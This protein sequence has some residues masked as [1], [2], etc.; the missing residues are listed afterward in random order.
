[1]AMVVAAVGTA[2]AWVGQAAWALGTYATYAVAGA[3]GLSLGVSGAIVSGAAQLALSAAATALMTPSIGRG[4]SPISFKAD[5]SAPISGVMGRFG[6]GGR[7]LHANVWGKDN[8]YLSFAVALSLGPIQSVEGFTA[9]GEA[10]TFPGAQGLAADVEPYRNKMW[11][12]YRLGLPTDAYLSPPTGVSDG[13]PA[14]TEWTSAHTLPG[15]AQTFWTMKNNSKREGYQSGV[16][17][18]LWTLLGMKVWDPRLDSTYPGGS[19]SQRRTDWTTWAYSANPYLHALA[20]VRGHHKL[21]AGGTI[22]T[23]KRLAGVGAPDAAIDIAAF[24]EGANVADANSWEIS[25][26]WTTADDKWQTLAAMLQAGGGVPISQGAQI[27]CMVEA[28]RTSLMTVTGED[29]VGSVSLNVM[30]SRRDRPNTVIPRV[31]LEAHKFEEVALGAVTSSTYVTEDAGESRVV[32]TAYRF[33]GLAKQGAELAGYGL[34]NT[35][36][37]LKAS[38]PC[39][40]Y[41]LGLRAGDAFTVTEPELGLSGQKFVVQRRSFDPASAI[42]TLDV[43]SETDAKHAWAL[44]QSADAPASPSLTAPDPVPATP[45]TADW[46]V[47]ARPV[48]SSGVQQPGLIV[49]GPTVGENIGAVLIEYST[50]SSGP[51]QQAYSGPPTIATV[52]INGL[53]GG[54]DYYV[55]ITYWSVRGVPSAQLVKGPYTAPGLTAGDVTPITPGNVAGTPSLSITSTIAA[56]GS[57]VSRLSGSWTPPASALTYVVE[58]DNG[59]VTTQFAAPEA[60]I[61]D[62]IVTT[63][64][65]YRYRVKA[66][67]RTGTLSAAWSSWSG[68]V[69]AGGDTTAPGVITSPSI[70][71]QLGTIFAEWTNPTDDDFDHV[72][73]YRHTA[74]VVGSSTLVGTVLA[75]N[76]TLYV[77]LALTT[78]Y[79]WAT[80]VDRTGNESAKTA[81]GSAQ[82]L[83]VGD[84]ASDDTVGWGDITTRP[85]EL[86][87]GRITTALN[88][89]GVLQTAIPSALADSSNILRRTSGGLYTGDLTATEGA[90]W[91]TNL[92]G[93]PTELTDGRIAT[94][95]NAS[96]VLQ[97]AIPSALADT[98]NILRRTAG[99]L[100]TGALDANRI[101]NTN[102]LTDGANL[103]GT[104]A[105]SGVSSRPTELTDGRIGT[106]L[107]ASGVL[108]TAIPSALADTSNILRRT[109]GGVFTGSL[110]A[111]QN[112]GAL[113]DLNTVSAAQIDTGAV[114]AIKLGSD[115]VTTAKVLAGAITPVYAALTT[116]TVNWT[117]SSAEKDLQTVASV[118]VTRGKVIVRASFTCDLNAQG[119]S[120]VVGILRLYRGGSEIFDA[121]TTQGPVATLASA[122]S[123]VFS[124]QWVLDFID[125]PGAGTYTYKIAFDPGH[126][127]D[128]DIRRRF[129]S[130]T[131]ME[132]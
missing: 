23:T 115:A 59:T 68:N 46:T 36:E 20:W 129:L 16:P 39:K 6:V 64:P 30:A 95:L 3:T 12:T 22:D 29:I 111:T 121:Q 45:D 60:S 18:P 75:N 54:E 113:A 13:S 83:P 72:K 80:T 51:W 21:V 56:D 122:S 76:A 49:T 96:G 69:A 98:S 118:V 104:A 15:F 5:P 110:A 97:T 67:S 4:G 40:P 88:G 9:S 31:R 33:V 79:F 77:P 53:V 43:R 10:V 41:L 124:K 11:Q 61:A 100:Y 50:S 126:T 8:L 37:T 48:E 85:T 7:Q 99:G 19:G 116:G 128:G 131:P 82:A 35:R 17:A 70:T 81:I 123:F 57:Q 62:R 26:E 132:G 28:P 107:N 127:A 92:T 47:A 66:L 1:M 24:V 112:T 117:A 114:T 105:W 42:V 27:S 102:E 94:G 58:I 73:I 86:T 91:G 103:G 125:D 108:Q 44:G 120:G 34:A 87:D 74:N 109:G 32:E 119:S 55:G 101:T 2:V 52:E 84:L 38:I 63:G 89:S 93:R 25:G 65:T 130:V 14:M 90:A 106:A 78:Y 71:G